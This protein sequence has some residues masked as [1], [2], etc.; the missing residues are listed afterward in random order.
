MNGGM[1]GWMNEG[2]DERMD[3]GGLGEGEESCESA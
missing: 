1:K 3:D 2:M